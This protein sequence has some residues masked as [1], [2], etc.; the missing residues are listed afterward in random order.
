MTESEEKLIK[1][2]LSKMQNNKLEYDIEEGKT[3]IDMCKFYNNTAIYYP[4]ILKKNIIDY[5][6]KIENDYKLFIKLYVS[7]NNIQ[8]P[9]K[10]NTINYNNVPVYVFILKNI[11]SAKEF[12][13]KYEKL[14]R[15]LKK[16]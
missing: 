4:Q 13:D 11:K 5:Y 8:Q 7:V 9:S 2:I 3:L 10:C 12:V 1:E 15:L 16:C 6:N 14:C